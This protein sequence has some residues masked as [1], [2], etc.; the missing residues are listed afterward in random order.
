MHSFYTFLQLFTVAFVATALTF[1]TNPEVATGEYLEWQL[2]IKKQ[3][4]S[5][6]TIRARSASV[7][8]KT[9]GTR[10]QSFTGEVTIFGQIDQPFIVCAQSLDAQGFTYEASA[11]VPFPFSDSDKSTH[12]YMLTLSERMGR[13][14]I[15]ESQPWSVFQKCVPVPSIQ[16]QD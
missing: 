2:P 3:S 12:L 16:T 15:K 7:A 8:T 9:Q 6:I 4:D 13:I 5:S 1:F 14:A 10:T 11:V